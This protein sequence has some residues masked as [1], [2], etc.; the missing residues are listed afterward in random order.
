V[1]NGSN[2]N[3]SRRTSDV[4]PQQ[5]DRRPRPVVI[6]AGEQRGYQPPQLTGAEAVAAAHEADDAGLVRQAENSL[7][8]RVIAVREG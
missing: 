8:A 7:G 2:G 6:R 3:D 5:R 1:S 4:G